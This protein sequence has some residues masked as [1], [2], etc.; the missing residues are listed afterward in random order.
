VVDLLV[1]ETT[2]PEQIVWDILIMQGTV[3]EEIHILVHITLGLTIMPLQ[4]TSNRGP[5]SMILLADCRT[6]HIIG[7][8]VV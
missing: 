3:V 7:L 4:T 1:G 6:G 5:F 2:T 8:K